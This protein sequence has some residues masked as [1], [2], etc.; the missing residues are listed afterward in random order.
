MYL[1]VRRTLPWD[2]KAYVEA[3]L[4]ERA[5]R[6]AK[7]WD[8]TFHLEYHEYRYRLKE[9]AADSLRAVRGTRIAALEEIPDGA[10]VVPTD[11]DDWFAPDLAEQIQAHYNP[12]R[13]CLLWRHYTIELP[14][15]LRER[16]LS[17]WRLRVKR[18]L[19]C[20][21]NNY[22]LVK[23][24]TSMSGFGSHGAGSR[25][26]DANKALVQRLPLHL[27]VQ[28]RNLSSKSIGKRDPKPP[29]P[30]N[31]IERY[32]RFVALYAG[33]KLPSE[34]AWAR[35]YLNQVAKLTSELKLR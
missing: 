26:F 22:A 10:I 15:R 32:R 20:R 23:S 1:W 19:T 2:D 12:E 24:P 5:R 11:D 29:T 7:V 16:L 3:H 4:V 9:I 34:V 35:P 6:L 18:T 8:Q 33:R 30:A 21:T 28:N 14:R 27:N 31:L 25:Y 13:S 17:L